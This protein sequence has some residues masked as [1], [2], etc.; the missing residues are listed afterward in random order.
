VVVELAS[1]HRLP[2]MFIARHWAWVFRRAAD[3]VARI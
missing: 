3:Y 2:S 1:T